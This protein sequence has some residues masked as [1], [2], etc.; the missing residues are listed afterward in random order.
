MSLEADG[1]ELL[2]GA[3]AGAL[4]TIEGIVA[5]VPTKA[6]TRLRNVPGLASLLAPAGPIGAIA[7]RILGTTCQPVRAILFD[8]TPDN[9][10]TLPWHQDRAIAVA[11]RL[12]VD[13]FGPWTLK[14]G[15]H[16]VEPP[17]Q[18]LAEIITLR[19]HLDAV[20]ATNAPLLVAPASHR[21]GRI[22]QAEI[23]KVVRRCG[24]V[25]CLADAG[26]VW[27]YST[28]IV[29]ASEA[30]IFPARRRVLQV[31]YAASELPGGLRWLGV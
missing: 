10:W 19:V 30:A 8:K 28:P 9:N 24:T 26:D 23:A 6:G 7:A 31:D 14:A 11:A 22:S 27:V 15:M 5:N 12:E 18:L 29:H 20:P 3:I 21:L 13:G 17:A 25:A 16:H 2:P 1:S 4:P